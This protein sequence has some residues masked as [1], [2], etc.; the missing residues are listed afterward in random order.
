MKGEFLLFDLWIIVVFCQQGQPIP[1]NYHVIAENAIKSILRCP[2]DTVSGQ[3]SNIFVP[4][5]V[6]APA[7]PTVHK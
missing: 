7:Y 5:W 3:H 6:T 4:T 2:L 1:Q